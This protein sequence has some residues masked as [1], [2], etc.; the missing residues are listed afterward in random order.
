LVK[1]SDRSIVAASN[2][3]GRHFAKKEEKESKAAKIFFYGIAEVPISLTKT[4]EFLHVEVA[5]H[6]IHIWQSQK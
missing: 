2:A 5:T 6:N 4:S 1:I 3:V